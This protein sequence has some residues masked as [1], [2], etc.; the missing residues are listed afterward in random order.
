MAS[1]GM[2]FLLF[3]PLADR[4][5]GFVGSYAK[6]HETSSFAKLSVGVKIGLVKFGETRCIMNPMTRSYR[7]RRRAERQDRT[8]QK[9]VEAAI[10]LHQDKGLAATTMGDVAER[11][12]VGRVTVYRH[13]P[14]EAALVGACSGQYFERYPLPDPEPW[15]SIADPVE[16]LR[17]GLGES[18]AYHR[19]TEPMMAGVL[20]EARDHPL[21]APY[22]DHWR[23]CAEVLARGWPAKLRRQ[24]QLGAACALAIGFDTWRT[25]AR[26]EGLTD[27][28]AIALMLRL[29]RDLV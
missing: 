13:F 9:I 27:A 1:S 8:R 2:T 4:D 15:L 20:A 10:A 25:L 22:H 14:D 18:Y 24:H 17:R 19:E 21:M 16:R 29:T 28:Q 5:G 12:G 23:R 7:L 3:R 11:A 26:D 6:F